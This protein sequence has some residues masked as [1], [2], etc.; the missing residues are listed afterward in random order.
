[1]GVHEKTNTWNTSTLRPVPPP[2]SPL[3]SPNRHFSTPTLPRCVSDCTSGP[4]QTRPDHGR[5][6]PPH[7]TVGRQYD[8][9]PLVRTDK[10]DTETDLDTKH[11]DPPCLRGPCS[12]H[13]DSKVES[14]GHRVHRAFREEARLP[15]TRTGSFTS[16]TLSCSPRNTEPL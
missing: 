8:P 3:K 4:P 5:K 6:G 2:P 12:I 11:R 9:R 10:R 7:T 13:L 16:T 1:M 14:N 15:S